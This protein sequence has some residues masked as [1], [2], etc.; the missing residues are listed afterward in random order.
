TALPA[1]RTV[2]SMCLFVFAISFVHFSSGHVRDAWSSEIALHH[3]GI[4]LALYV[5]LQDYRFLLMDAFLRFFV[6][7]A[8][9]GGFIVFSLALNFRFRLMHWAENPFIAGLL[10][11][12]ACLVLIALVYIRGKLQLALTR[13]VF[14]RSDPEAAIRRVREAGRNAENENVFLE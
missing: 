2:M 5:L 9:A 13:I 6:N 4:P 3:A 11:V 10:L 14:G 7:A 1:R 8:A 12:A